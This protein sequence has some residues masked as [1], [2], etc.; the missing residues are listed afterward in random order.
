MEHEQLPKLL[1]T[2]MKGLVMLDQ[3]A[4][5]LVVFLPDRG[6]DLLVGVGGD[7]NVLRNASRILI[8]LSFFSDGRGCKCSLRTFSCSLEHHTKIRANWVGSRIVEGELNGIVLLLVMP[9]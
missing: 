6:I 5:S 4:L 1:D 7:A 2:G 8:S 9:Y 3:I